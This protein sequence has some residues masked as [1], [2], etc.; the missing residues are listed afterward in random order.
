MYHYADF[1]CRLDANIYGIDFISFVIKDYDTKRVIFEVSRDESM[2]SD[3]LAALK[4]SPDFDP[5]TLRKIDYRFDADVLSLPRVATKLKFTVGDEEVHKFRMIERHYFK[6][7][8]IKSFDFTFPFCMPNSS[9]MWESEYDLPPMD[10]E[11][12]DDIVNNPLAVRSDSFYFVDGELIMHNKARYTYYYSKA[13]EAKLAG[14]D[15]SDDEDAFGSGRNH[16]SSKLASSSE[17]DDDED[18]EYA[19]KVARA[20]H[21]GK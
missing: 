5:D 1:L 12:I 2:S 6:G 16:T 10:S 14:D 11:L 20:E 19:S 17:E 7:K 9:N 21:S 3:A 8:L 13:R 15:Y 4:R 18:E